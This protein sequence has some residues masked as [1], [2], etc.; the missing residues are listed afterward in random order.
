MTEH[1]K[2][3]R[4]GSYGRIRAAWTRGRGR[5]VV[6]GEGE[7]IGTLE[8][9]YLDSETSSP[10]W[11]TVKTGLFGSKQSFVLLIDS[12]LARGKVVVPYDKAQV[13][14]APAIDP[15][16]ELSDQEE[17]QLY[18]H[19]GREYTPPAGDIDSDREH[20]GEDV[21]GPSTDDAMTRS[22]EELRVGTS[23]R[24]AGAPACASTW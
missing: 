6:D 3:S 14:D 15:D 19:Y 12:E 1:R 4:D 2:R 20:V 21:S 8:E 22:E 5:E 16:G 18:S 10:E 13:K 17:Q 23:Q 11:A 7:K 9:I 24:S